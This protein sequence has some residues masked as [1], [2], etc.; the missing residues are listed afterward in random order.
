ME[1]KKETPPVDRRVLKRDLLA[2]KAEER[3]NLWLEET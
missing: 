1:S 3:R 2:M